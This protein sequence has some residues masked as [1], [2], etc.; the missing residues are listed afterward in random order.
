M[1]KSFP[2]RVSPLRRLGRS[3]AKL[4]F[5][6]GPH[7]RVAQILS[8]PVF[9]GAEWFGFEDWQQIGSF[10]PQVL[11]GPASALQTLAARIHENV[12]DLSS[13]DHAIFVTT[14]C[15]QPPLS[16]TARV[17]LW[18]TFGVPVYELLI[19]AGGKLLASECEAHN[20]WHLE[21]N[22][23]LETADGELCVAALG[24]DL[25]QPIGLTARAE[26][27]LCPCGRAG[28]RILQVERKPPARVGRRLAAIA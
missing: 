19:G 18:Q 4:P 9:E 8:F 2:D 10:E 5:P 3:R 7:V 16:D 6:A 12:L 17:V 28:T 23:K 21:P 11:V 26:T 25:P 13:V 27:G 20:G 14:E 15:G 1:M 24:K 22:V